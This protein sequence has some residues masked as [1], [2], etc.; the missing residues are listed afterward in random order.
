MFTEASGTLPIEEVEER[1]SVAQ[2]GRMQMETVQQYAGLTE[3]SAVTYRRQGGG[4]MIRISRQTRFRNEDRS[5]RE[6]QVVWYENSLR[7]VVIEA[8]THNDQCL[9]VLMDLIDRTTDLAVRHVRYQLAHNQPRLVVSPDSDDDEQ[10]FLVQD[11]AITWKER[12]PRY[13]LFETEACSATFERLSADLDQRQASNNQDRIRVNAVILVRAAKYVVEGAL[14]EPAASTP[15]LH[16][17]ARCPEFEL[18]MI[19][20]PSIAATY[21]RRTFNTS[22]LY[23]NLYIEMIEFQFN[24]LVRERAGRDA[25]RADLDEHAPTARAMRLP[26]GLD[27]AVQRML[28]RTLQFCHV[29]LCE[30]GEGCVGWHRHGDRLYCH[31]GSI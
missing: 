29:R 27:E 4:E 26:P 15:L 25:T 13:D 21:D 11:V 10:T 23:E 12:Y 20:F 24:L 1:T 31:P 5:F 19:A 3:I 8:N 30:D 7:A 2:S 16:Q 18:F 9:N 28:S 17:P 6:T 14:L 22:L